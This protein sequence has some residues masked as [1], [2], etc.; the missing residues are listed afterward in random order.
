M[1]LLL[2]LHA[3]CSLVALKPTHSSRLLPP[4]EGEKGYRI[5]AGLHLPCITLFRQTWQEGSAEMLVFLYSSSTI[6]LCRFP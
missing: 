4:E 2:T 6:L 5:A 3:D 1:A